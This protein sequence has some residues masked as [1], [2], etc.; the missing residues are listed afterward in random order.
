LVRCSNRIMARPQRRS[1]TAAR[2]RPDR[3][4]QTE[5]QGRRPTIC[6][7]DRDRR[8]RATSAGHRREVVVTARR[9]RPRHVAWRK[10]PPVG[11]FGIV[12]FRDRRSCA[13][14]R[15][16][17]PGPCS[18]S[19]LDRRPRSASILRAGGDA[20]VRHRLASAGRILFHERLCQLALKVPQDPDLCLEIRGR[21]EDP[22]FG[23]KRRQRRA[24]R[25]KAFTRRKKLRP[26]DDRSRRR[27]ASALSSS[28]SARHSTSSSRAIS[29]AISGEKAR[30]RNSTRPVPGSVRTSSIRRQWVRRASMVAEGGS[31]KTGSTSKGSP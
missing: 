29:C 2:Q 16:G 19:L 23:A 7:S 27:A 22:A 3:P 14:R 8:V 6:A 17:S 10:R 4:D 11:H 13:A 20:G 26:G 21:I 12:P 25:R 9:L 5:E 15:S 31:A 24:R 1:R 28:R 30:I 18:A